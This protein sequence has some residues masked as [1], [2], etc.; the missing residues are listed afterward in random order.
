MLKP[1]VC[2]QL[3]AMAQNNTEHIKGFTLAQ[4]AYGCDPTQWNQSADAI[5]INAEFEPRPLEHWQLQKN[6]EKAEAIHRQELAKQRITRLRNSSSRPTSSYQVGDWVCVWRKATL[7]S[8]HKESNPEARYIGPGRV[9]MIEPHVLPEGRSSV[10]WVLMG[11]AL[12][13]CAPE[14]LRP[15]TE[16]EITTEIVKLGEL[17]VQPLSELLSRLHSSVDVASKPKFD[18]EK[19]LLPEIPP[20]DGV[21][22][23]APSTIAQ[24]PSDWE[25]DVKQGATSS[26]THSRSRSA[27]YERNL[28][29]IMNQQKLISLNKSRQL[30][31]LPPLLS[32]PS[33]AA[34]SIVDEWEYV[35]GGNI[36]LRRHHTPR[37][38]LFDPRS[39]PDCP[40]RVRDLIPRRMT[41]WWDGKQSG[42]YN[43]NLEDPHV[44]NRRFERP[45]TGSTEFIVRKDAKR[46][47]QH[48]NIG[49]DDEAEVKKVLVSNAM[50]EE[51]EVAQNV[52]MLQNDQI[53]PSEVMLQNDIPV[54]YV[55]SPAEEEN[56][57]DNALKADQIANWIDEEQQSEWKFMQ[58]MHSSAVLDA[59]EACFISFSV[60]SMEAFVADP[61]AYMDQKLQGPSKEINFRKLTPAD[62]TLMLEA[63]AR[64]VSEI[65]R[66]KSLR[67]LQEHVPDQVLKERCLPMRW[68]LTWKPV[69]PPQ[70]PPNDGKPTV[71]RPDGLSKAKARVVLIGYK[72]PDLAGEMSGRAPALAD[73]ITDT[74]ADWSTTVFAGYSD[75]PPYSGIW[76][77]EECLSSGRSRHWNRSSL[78]LGC[79]RTAACVWTW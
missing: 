23:A 66:S 6:R 69:D 24:T 37:W 63:M 3:A 30:E 28:K 48:F 76:R 58:L 46:K 51:F 17:A 1:R 77:C 54:Q 21:G 38:D 4:W 56:N 34:A 49:T 8:R 36:L 35:A 79:A 53:A 32:L 16:S 14:Q 19:D 73:F 26:R 70:T 18:P 61:N 45:W 60:D 68:I 74:V 13:R 2:G 57:S 40:F 52:D 29:E 62:Q 41:R 64:E 12:W 25:K 72:H 65:L 33:S 47:A 22:Q 44:M 67:A 55:N 71:L 9:A 31:G 50:A 42:N 15:A 39:V 59:E 75:G 78:Y 43:D 7:K 11:T 5:A 10:I 27:D 20:A